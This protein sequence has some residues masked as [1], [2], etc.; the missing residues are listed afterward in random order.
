MEINTQTKVSDVIK[1]NYKTTEL[2][3]KLGIDFC[4][5]GK[6]SLSEACANKNINLDSL[7]NDLKNYSFNNDV[8]NDWELDFL[9]DYIVNA[10]H[11]YLRKVLPRI[12]GHLKTLSEKHSVKYPELIE[13][14][15]EYEKLQ[16]ELEEHMLKEENILFPYIKTLVNAGRD[17]STLNTPPFGSI[18][19][20]I[21]VM[22]R[23][24]AEAG[25]FLE[26]IRNLTNDFLI[27]DSFCNTHR[28]TYNELEELNNDLHKHIHLENNILFPKAKELEE[29]IFNSA[30]SSEGS[31]C[32]CNL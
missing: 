27:E 14:N 23:E 12:K 18:D 10:H 7:L 22:E 15:S 3:E 11:T 28:I 26:T 31:A 8:F 13:I 21:S 5:G 25:N 20:P 1:F 17:N 4:C 9:A 19:N 6:K 32:M 24:H 2:F 16:N 29:K 30:C